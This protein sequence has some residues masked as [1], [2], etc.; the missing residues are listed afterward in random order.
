VHTLLWRVIR[1][2]GLRELGPEAITERIVSNLIL[3]EQYVV[4]LSK[5]WHVA[6]WAKEFGVSEQ[7]LC[8]AVA[9]VGDRAEVVQ[10]YLG[11]GRGFDR[12]L[13]DTGRRL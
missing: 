11:A 7:M 5:P 10:L 12:T 2:S 8:A 4:D 3:S 1:W 6:W 13:S 9:L